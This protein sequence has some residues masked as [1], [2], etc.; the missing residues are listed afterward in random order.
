MNSSSQRTADSFAPRLAWW[1]HDWFFGLLLA[2]AT[3]LAYQP[4]WHAGF[5]W[6]DDAFLTNNPL[7]KAADGLY[8]F[9]CTT[10]APDYFPITSTTL[11]L[12]WR[13]WGSNPLGY[14]LVNVFLHAA[15]ALV[16][17]RVLARLNIPGAKL[18]AAIF[19]LHPV[20]VESVAWV[21]ERKNTLTMFFY[22]WALLFYLR[23]E[24]LGRRRWYW[25]GA[26]AFALALLSKTAVATLPLVLLMLA[27]WRRGRIG[28]QDVLRSIPFFVV[29]ALLGVITVWFQYHRAIGPEVVRGDS[30]WARL[31]GAGWAA[32]FYLYKTF[33]PLNLMFVYPRWRIDGAN[34][35]AYVPGLLLVL[36]FLV[37]WVYRRGWGK[38]LLFGLGYFLVML[39]PVLGFLDIYFMRFSLVTDHWQYFAFIGPIALAAAGMTAAKRVCGAIMPFPGSI[40][41]GVLLALL[42]M[43]T[44]QRCCIFTDSTSLWRATASR[45]PGS[46]LVQYNLGC[47]LLETGDLEE[48]TARF[49]KALQADPGLAEAHNNLGSLLLQKGLTDQ[50]IAHFQT[51]LETRSAFPDAHSNLGGALLQKGRVEEAVAQFQKAL[52]IAPNDALTGYNLGSA[53]LKCGRVDEA[54]AQFQR[55]LEIRPDL[56]EA[57]SK[58]GMALLRKGRED[59]AITCLRR[60]LE[61]NPSL[62]NAQSDLGNLLLQKGLIDEA[63]AHYEAAVAIQPANATFL[64][65]LAWVLATCPMPQVRNGPRAVELAQQSERLGSRWDPA[66]LGTL[67]AAYAEAGRFPEALRT[68]QR[69]LALATA[70]TNSAQVNILRSNIALFS[71]NSPFHDRAQTN[72]SLTLDHPLKDGETESQ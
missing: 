63:V 26:G 53:L 68:A 47:V 5:I 55:V 33:W 41:C 11:W 12:E 43:L 21:T 31:A 4:V 71:A 39:L 23:F 72:R 61:L 35:L 40:L 59:E 50:A 29:A 46:S 6:D 14:H 69:A 22:A 1:K 38:S 19:A 2:G 65:N 58:L 44:W 70:Q 10:E 34:V 20:N 60:A 49:Q 42:G 67:A 48:A 18:A 36:V 15:S 52:E 13:L 30:F 66:I 56:P 37:C 24:D 7:I 62:A 51:A 3:L 64:N 54:I 25:L 57:C 45:N 16:L 9:W 17:W 32:W 28:R 8:R 27:W